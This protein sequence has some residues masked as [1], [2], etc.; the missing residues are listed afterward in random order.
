MIPA[1]QQA[2]HEWSEVLGS[3]HVLTDPPTLQAFGTSTFETRQRV[4]AVLR[5]AT[6][7]HI[8][9]SLRIANKHRTPVYVISSGFN[10]GY[11]SRVPVED[12]CVILDLRRMNRILDFS[13]ELAYIT[14]EPGSNA[15]AGHR[16]SSAE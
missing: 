5:P 11:G 3:E 8:Q 4:P 9:L 14:V 10:W 15:A 2:L 7:E 6:R 12:N 1:F 13:E 16:I